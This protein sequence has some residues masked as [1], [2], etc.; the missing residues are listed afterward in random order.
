MKRLNLK[1][2]F[3]ALLS[4]QTLIAMPGKTIETVQEK[5]VSKTTVENQ[6]NYLLQTSKDYNDV[7]LVKKASLEEL[8]ADFL[9]F[10][11]KSENELGSLKSALEKKNSEFE[12][13]KSEHHN[14]QSKLSEISKGGGEIALLGVNVSKDLYHAIMWS[15]VLTLV[16][17][18]GFLT[19]RFKKANEIT[20]NSKGLLCD[21]EDEFETFKRNAIEREQKLRRQLQDEIN[22]QKPKVEVS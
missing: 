12:Q 5:P 1:M 20:Q 13:L 2:G 6:I 14:A 19:R 15:L 10:I 9:A 21:L 11:S 7:K 17:A 8:R 18:V 4:L 16:I 3:V 22:K